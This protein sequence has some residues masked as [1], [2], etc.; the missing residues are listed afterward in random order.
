MKKE[1]KKLCQKLSDMQLWAADEMKRFASLTCDPQM[2]TKYEQLAGFNRMFYENIKND[3]CDCKEK[4]KVAK[5]ADLIMR[6]YYVQ[7]AVCDAFFACAAEEIRPQK[8]D[9]ITDRQT[10]MCRELLM[11]LSV[12]MGVI[13]DSQK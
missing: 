5:E 12:R 13:N 2:K 7:K 3:A 4:S 8:I 6:A 9:E 11:E 1:L 10:M